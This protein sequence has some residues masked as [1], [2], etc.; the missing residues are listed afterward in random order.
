MFSNDRRVKDETLMPKY[1][2]KTQHQIDRAVASRTGIAA[3]ERMTTQPRPAWM[4]DKA[5]LPKK[6]P[7]KQP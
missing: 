1:K 7:G 5:L 4:Q 6:P 2:Q 3:N